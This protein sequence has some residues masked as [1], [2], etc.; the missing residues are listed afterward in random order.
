MYPKIY[1]HSY[2]Y[3]CRGLYPVPITN[4]TVNQ[5]SAA[6]AGFGAKCQLSL[7]TSSL[8]SP[9]DDDDDADANNANGMCNIT[10][11]ASGNWELVEG[12]PH[13]DELA[14]N[15]MPPNMVS[16]FNETE[17]CRFIRLG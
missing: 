15:I 14:G 11:I 10:V 12:I 1:T 9:G 6:S 3:G 13:F 17:T 4:R 7:S 8:S 16:L 5:E 2:A